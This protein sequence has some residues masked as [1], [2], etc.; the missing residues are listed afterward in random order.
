MTRNLS[1]GGRK[2][3]RTGKRGSKNGRIRDV[4]LLSA[5]ALLLIFAVWRIFY[6]D[7]DGGDGAVA[8]GSDSEQRLCALLG[9]IDGVGNVRVM[10]CED[11]DGVESVV[12]VC[13]GANDLK[14]DGRKIRKDLSDERIK[15]EIKKC[16]TKRKL[17]SCRHWS[18]CSR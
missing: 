13:E 8:V 9:E 16:Q 7:A 5:L 4:L 10:I 14:V 18:F 15:K 12:V 17:L 6:T 1:D 2:A 11:E 3:D